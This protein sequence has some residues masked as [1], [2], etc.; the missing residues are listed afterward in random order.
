VDGLPG[1]PTVGRLPRQVPGAGVDHGGVGGVDGDGVDVLDLGVTLG[2]DAP[3][4]SPSVPRA[5]DAGQGSHDHD[6]RV[7]RGQGEG[8]DRLA[9]DAGQHGEGPSAVVAAG[10][11]APAPAQGPVAHEDRAVVGHGQVIQA[12]PVQREAGLEPTPEASRVLGAI[13]HA[14]RRPQV[15]DLGLAGDRGQGAHVA[16]GRADGPPGLRGRRR[17]E[18][19]EGPDRGRSEEGLEGCP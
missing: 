15:H 19:E 9:R 2:A 18:Q 13:E 14:S 12:H 11:A 6:P 1:L 5:E 17:G 16:P 8:L 7:R 10:H 4:A 3:P